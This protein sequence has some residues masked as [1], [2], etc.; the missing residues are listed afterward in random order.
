MRKT[1]HEHSRSD[2]ARVDKSDRLKSSLTEYQDRNI[3]TGRTITLDVSP[4]LQRLQTTNMCSP[5]LVPV[6]APRSRSR[7]PE[8]TMSPRH[9]KQ[10]SLAVKPNIRRPLVPQ[11]KL[12]SRSS[13]ST[14]M[15]PR[16]SPTTAGASRVQLDFTE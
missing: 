7:V 4:N 8:R 15:S 14:G 5:R 2:D 12:L 3:L 16:M 13:I 1:A 10:L 9:V 6:I 11:F